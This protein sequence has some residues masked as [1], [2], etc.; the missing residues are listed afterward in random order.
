[1]NAKTVLPAAVLSL[2]AASCST[3][4]KETRRER[5]PQ[6]KDGK[7]RNPEPMKNDF[8]LALKG[9]FTKS[10]ITVPP[11]PL[12]VVQVDSRQFLT[13]P[14]SGLRVTWLGHSTNILEIDGHRFL[15]DPVW[16]K[17]SS[18]VQWAGPSRWYEP[19]IALDSLPALDAVLISH[20]HFDHL[21]RGVVE[22]LKKRDPRYVVGLG[23]GETLEKWGVP[24]HRITELD[25]WDSAHVGEVEIVS[26]PARHASGRGLF[27]QGK[28]L[29]MGFAIKADS[30]SVY[31]SGDTGPFQAATEIGKRLG[32]FDFTLIECGQYDPAWPDWHMAPEQSLS[33]HK[34]VRGKVMMPVHWGLFRLAYH[35]WKDPVERL[36]AANSDGSAT[37]VVPRPG[38]SIEPTERQEL[39]KWWEGI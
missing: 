22:G 36:L 15:L 11:K 17:R 18:P 34:A 9:N 7:F 35:S 8:W 16:A 29:W 32:P 14:A 10:P 27:D 5:S 12:P 37:I 13:P 1:M 2:C 30:H 3:D 19:L 28:T 33:L 25:W 23:L 38:Q 31:Y 20:N 4:S 26:T 24:A 6:W 21:D 39:S